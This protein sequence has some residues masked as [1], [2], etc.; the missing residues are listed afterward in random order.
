MKERLWSVK[1]KASNGR[2]NEEEERA[3]DLVIFQ[4][5]NRQRDKP[6]QIKYPSMRHL[7][8]EQKAKL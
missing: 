5:E 4:E 6:L 1:E 7:V 3:A 2:I 8:A